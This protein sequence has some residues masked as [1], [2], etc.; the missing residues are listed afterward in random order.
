LAVASGCSTA[1]E[2]TAS[3]TTAYAAPSRSA[4][5]RCTAGQPRVVVLAVDDEHRQARRAQL[6]DAVGLAGQ[7]VGHPE[8]RPGAGRRHPVA[9]E[10]LGGGVERE[11]PHVAGVERVDGGHEGRHPLLGERSHQRQDVHPRAGEA[12]GAGAH[13]HQRAEGLRPLQ[14]RGARDEAAEAVAHEV[15]RSLAQV[16][17]DGE[18]VAGEHLDA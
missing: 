1:G 15:H 3:G 10:A 6:G 5:S 14:H 17:D 9:Q 18:Q 12:G 16:V 2:C 4:I 8:Q 7:G 11:P 13:Q